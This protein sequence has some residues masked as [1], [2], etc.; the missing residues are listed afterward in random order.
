MKNN[1]GLTFIEIMISL[2]IISVSF[3]GIMATFGAIN[4]AIQSSKSRTLASNLAQEKMQILKQITYTRLLITPTPSYKTIAGTTIS[5]P[6][7]NTYYT[8][9]DIYEGGI[10]FK[11]YTYVQMA[12]EV[13]GELVYLGATPDTGMKAVTITV[14]W[15]MGS[16]EKYFQ[17][18]SIFSNPNT[19]KTNCSIQGVV[20]NSAG[21]PSTMPINEATVVIAENMAWRD[22]TAANGTYYIALY[23]GSYSIYASA[24]GYFTTIIPVSIGKF[25][26]VTQNI[27][28][29]QMSSGTIIGFAW[30]NPNPVIS[31]VVASTGNA[32]G[33]KEEYIELFNP[34]TSYIIMADAS[35]GV[36][37]QILYQHEDAAFP[38]VINLDYRVLPSS[39]PPNS[40]YLIANTATVNAFGIPKYADAYYSGA[41]YG[42]DIIKS[43]DAG[44]VGLRRVSDNAWIDR[45]G[46][47]RN[48]GTPKQAPLYETDGIDQV[49][50]FQDN[51]QY[52]R[53][54][55]TSGVTTGY[56]RCYDSGNNNKDFMDVI[57]M[58]HYP[59][60]SSNTETI[61]SGVPA[62][63]AIVSCEDGLSLGA[64]ARAKG[65]R[66]WAE[67]ELPE[68]ATGT[69][70]VWVTS[71]NYTREITT[72][73]IA[74]HGQRLLVPN[75]N[76]GPQWPMANYPSV[77]LSSE[78][79]GGFISGRVVNSY[80]AA[81]S[82]GIKVTAGGVQRTASTTSGRYV[83]PINTG[84]YSVTA[85]PNND[86]T[87]YVSQT[88]DNVTVNMG[89]VT[90][91]IDFVLS[92]GGR[93]SGWVTRDKINPLPGISM[94]ASL[95]ESGAVK[96]SEISGSNGRFT[97]VNLSTGIYKVAPELESGETSVPSYSTCTVTPGSNIFV[98][99]FTITGAYGRITGT[100][101][102]SGRPISTGVLIAASTSSFT[103]PPTL[104]SA[105]IITTPYYFT[106]SYEDGTYILEVRGSTLTPYYVRAFYP[107]VTKSSVT[108]NTL[109]STGTWVTPGQTTSGINFSW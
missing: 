23:D 47:D 61:I 81:I 66:I 92:Q 78:A 38:S 35:G 82:P 3:L 60:N 25:Q 42:A 41:N 11:R 17:L 40:Y 2:V 19:L 76:T 59:K 64:T 71:N 12:Q 58:S 77:F 37:Y 63:G 75:S 93:I 102:A 15:K 91:G 10:K 62:V 89:E 105:S 70:M 53:R 32:Y 28:M 99:S 56:A 36:N 98:G 34:T 87:L 49:I 100:V 20:Y 51:E 72:V 31:Q 97:I 9:E 86:N 46:W 109:L 21:L 69:W 65:D 33:F 27:P 6:Y 43:P 30:T 45:V 24:R 55:S 83:I 85:N 79:T 14:V 54:T 84:T 22:L 1:K 5:I 8:P 73:T 94:V 29:V 16:E 52:I 7:D 67:F 50:G 90:S 68:I 13:N 26:N 96:G 39:I 106:N 107:V 108:I 101:R 48:P 104:S 88:V 95:L 57:P 18:R 80:G 44:G 74:S 4:T 103:A